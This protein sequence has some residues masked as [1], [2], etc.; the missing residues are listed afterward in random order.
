L[1]YDF[2]SLIQE[3]EAVV[4]VADGSA[5]LGGARAL[6]LALLAYWSAMAVNSFAAMA[7]SLPP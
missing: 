3:E 6:I 1:K 2:N 5:L 4:V 7:L